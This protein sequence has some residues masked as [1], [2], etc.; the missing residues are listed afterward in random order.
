MKFIESKD[1]CDQKCLGAL[2]GDHSGRILRKRD[3]KGIKREKER[4]REKKS[5]RK[6][7]RGKERERESNKKEERKID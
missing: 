5:K 6:K 3:K 1:G 4:K 7:K 2:E